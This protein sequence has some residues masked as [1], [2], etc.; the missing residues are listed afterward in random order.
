MLN[1][2]LSRVLEPTFW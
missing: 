2:G 1:E